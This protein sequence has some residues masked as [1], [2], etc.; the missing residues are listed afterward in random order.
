ML[1][2]C[3]PTAAYL[4]PRLWDNQTISLN[5]DDDSSA[6]NDVM[7]MEVGL[8]LFHTVSLCVS[9]FTYLWV[10]LSTI[11]DPFLEP[12]FF[13]CLFIFISV[14]PYLYIYPTYC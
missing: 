9:L 6:I 11:S 5:L 3:D 14:R 13:L 1:K 8:L 10:Y 7:N 12:L 4:G 2:V